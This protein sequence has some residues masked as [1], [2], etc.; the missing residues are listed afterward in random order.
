MTNKIYL[1]LLDIF[2]I[3]E[4]KFNN[5]SVEKIISNVGSSQFLGIK[6]FL[7]SASE[8]TRKQTEMIRIKIIVFLLIIAPIALNSATD[9]SRLRVGQ[10]LCP[11]PDNSY[12]YIDEKTQS[13]A[14]CTKEG[15][16]KG[17]I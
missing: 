7:R 9:C 4:S 13:V 8:T 5:G 15:T 12:K 2:K 10:F 16:A 17:K 1:K 11:D 14:G 6:L 3:L